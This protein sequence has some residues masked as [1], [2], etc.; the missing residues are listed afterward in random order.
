MNVIL[1]FFFKQ[2]I[3]FFILKR[4]L[5][6]GWQVIAYKKKTSVEK[7]NPTLPLDEWE[8]K[9]KMS[10]NLRAILTLI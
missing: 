4:A 3:N 10:N 6:D 7:A 5:S 2:K 8:S 1:K 9:K